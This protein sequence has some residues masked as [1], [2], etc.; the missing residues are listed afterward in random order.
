MVVQVERWFE[1]GEP[2]EKTVV[3]Q[4]QPL[5]VILLRLEAYESLGSNLAGSSFSVYD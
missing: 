4:R 5:L 3:S 2:T 1:Y